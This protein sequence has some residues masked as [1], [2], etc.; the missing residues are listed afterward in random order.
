MRKIAVLFSFLLAMGLASAVPGQLLTFPVG[1][2]RPPSMSGSIDYRL[3]YEKEQFYVYRPS[4]YNPTETWGLLVYISHADSW[5]GVPPGWD[6]VL[7]SNK[8][9]FVCPQRAGNGC[10]MRRRLGLGVLAALEMS[11]THR[12]DPNRIYAAGLSGGARTAGLLGFYQSDL[13]H[14]TIQ[15]CGADF[16]KPVPS[17][18]ATSHTDSNGN[19]NY[20]LFQAS[21]REVENARRN[22]KFVLITGSNDFRHGNILDLYEGGFLPDGFNCKLIDVPGMGHEDCKASVL[23]QALDFL[24]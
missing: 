22:Q 11:Q 24:K 21:A 17:V 3:N 8:L 13:F 19:T 23:Q 10:E 4:N 9:L 20:G 1:P 12:I 2:G 18:K 14:G 5:Q 6:S 15:D 16:Y 7:K